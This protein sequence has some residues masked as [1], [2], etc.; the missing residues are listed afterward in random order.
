MIFVYNGYKV[1]ELGKFL[2]FGNWFINEILF[3]R[4]K[5]E[6]YLYKDRL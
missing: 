4:K 1:V 5:M 6:C 2:F 3:F